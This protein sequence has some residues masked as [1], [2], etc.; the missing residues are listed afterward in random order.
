MPDTLGTKVWE[1]F[2]FWILLIV[3]TQAWEGSMSS[4]ILFEYDSRLR[5]EAV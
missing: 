3:E 4:I 5:V 2:Q 1:F